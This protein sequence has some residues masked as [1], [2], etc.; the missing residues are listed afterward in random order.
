M[1]GLVTGVS[2]FLFVWGFFG[3]FLL[4][5][6]VVCCVKLT[7]SEEILDLS[8]NL[9][10]DDSDV[11]REARWELVDMGEEAV[12]PLI[13]K[14]DS[15]DAKVVKDAAWV[16]GRVEDPRAVE[17][18]VELLGDESTSVAKRAAKA[19]VRIGEEALPAMLEQLGSDCVERRRLA[20]WFL[21]D[22]MDSGIGDALFEALKD[23]DVLVRRNAARAVGLLDV[24]DAVGA[25][26]VAL[27]DDDWRVRQWAAA[28]MT[29]SLPVR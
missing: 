28:T 3:Y 26:G 25:L 13:S 19:L 12:K 27:K 6:G 2:V 22:F 24:P 18:L 7:D 5:A 1:G 4:N 8:E 14:L 16:L 21:P 15:D 29:R 9:G 10:V 23:P 17:P 11:R 20:A